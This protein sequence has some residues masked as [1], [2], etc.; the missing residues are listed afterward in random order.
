MLRLLVLC[1]V[2]L[3]SFVGIASSSASASKAS[4]T[5]FVCAKVWTT[6][7]VLGVHSAGTCTPWNGPTLCASHDLGLDPSAH[8]YTLVCIPD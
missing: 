4:A 1:A 7:T 3:G 8:V 5:N 2:V 6:G